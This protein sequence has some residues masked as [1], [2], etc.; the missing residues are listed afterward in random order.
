MAPTRNKCLNSLGR[1]GNTMLKR[2][3]IIGY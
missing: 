3:D 1:T 2:Q